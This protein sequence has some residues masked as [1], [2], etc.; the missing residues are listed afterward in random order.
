MSDPFTSLLDLDGKHRP[1]LRLRLD[2]KEYPLR[3]VETL[4]A[5]EAFQLGELLAEVGGD[6]SDARTDW[7]VEQIVTIVAPELPV[8]LSRLNARILVAFYST[9][10]TNAVAR[11]TTPAGDPVPF[12]A[13]AR[14]SSRRRGSRRAS[15]SDC[16]SSSPCR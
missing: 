7:A 1:G 12:S 6:R 14:A 10:L 11:L 8:K 4:P 15:A 5:I 16:G 13:P 3:A 2:G 9:H